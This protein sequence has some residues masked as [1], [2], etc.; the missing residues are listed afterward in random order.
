MTIEAALTG[1]LGRDPELKTSQSW[2][3]LDADLRGRIRL[4]GDA[5]GRRDDL[6]LGSLLWRGRRETLRYGEEGKQGV[7]RGPL[8]AHF[9]VDRADGEKRIGL[10]LAAWRAQVVGVGALGKNK[11]PRKPKAPP[12]GE[13]PAATAQSTTRSSTGSGRLPAQPLTPKSRSEVT[14]DIG[15]RPRGARGVGGF[16]VGASG[17]ATPSLEP[18]NEPVRP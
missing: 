7:H 13:Q 14:D 8:D 16:G 2:Q 10:E 1:T 3:V 6:G 12:R 17:P 15:L 5:G 11:S 9:R 18:G 4:A